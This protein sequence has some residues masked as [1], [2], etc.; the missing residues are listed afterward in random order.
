[1]RST[2]GSYKIH[3]VLNTVFEKMA[4][5]ENQRI[6]IAALL[7]RGKTPTILGCSRFTFYRG[8]EW[9]AFKRGPRKRPRSQRCQ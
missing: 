4:S 9:V 8:K 5:D 6:T 3:R 7:S 1:M 2:M